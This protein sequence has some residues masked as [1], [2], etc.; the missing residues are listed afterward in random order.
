MGWYDN[1]RER[2]KE[3]SVRNGNVLFPTVADFATRWGRDTMYNVGG[4]LSD[5]GGILRD[6][7]NNLIEPEDKK[8]SRQLS[9]VFNRLDHATY[10]ETGSIRNS[11]RFHENSS[12]SI[13]MTSDNMPSE[14]VNLSFIDGFNADVGITSGEF[15]YEALSKSVNNLDFGI[16]KDIHQFKELNQKLY[17]PNHRQYDN[18][19]KM[20]GQL[21]QFRQHQNPTVTIEGPPYVVNDRKSMDRVGVKTEYSG[22]RLELLQSLAR[23]ANTE[24]SGNSITM[25]DYTYAHMQF[26]EMEKYQPEQFRERVETIRGM[27]VASMGLESSH[28]TNKQIAPISEPKQHVVPSWDERVAKYRRDNPKQHEPVVQEAEQE[29]EY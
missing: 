28:D 4:Q 18:Y 3:A 25:G 6:E 26:V 13:T 19:Q 1:I 23:Q 15:D 5:I 12:F 20:A 14:S 10:H 27:N 7:F 16:P 17:E 24:R 8:R 9:R 21:D 11:G 29:F 22:E 2:Y